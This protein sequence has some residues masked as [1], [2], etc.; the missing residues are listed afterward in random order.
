MSYFVNNRQVINRLAIDTSSS[1]TPSYVDLCCATERTLNLDLQEQDFSVFCDALRRHV[2]TGADVQIATT[3]KI[4]AQNTGVAQILSHI[5]TL[6]STGAI[7]Q[8]NNV[9]IQFGLLSGYTNSTLTYTTYNAYANIQIDNLGGGAEDVS[10]M[11]V[12]FTLNGTAQAQA[13]I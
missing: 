8:F 10:E 11:G 7:S 4:D 9:K 13:S 3:L 1:D 5:H 12:T 2:T 6:I